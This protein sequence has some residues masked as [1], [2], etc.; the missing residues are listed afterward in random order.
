M[1]TCPNCNG[2]K[3]VPTHELPFSRPCPT[4]GG[5]G[6]ISEAALGIY[7]AMRPE[8]PIPEFRQVRIIVFKSEDGNEPWIPKRRSFLK[9]VAALPALAFLPNIP[10][11]AGLS[12]AALQRAANAARDALTSDSYLTFIHPSVWFDLR[13]L[14]ARELWRHEYRAWRRGEGD[15]HLFTLEDLIRHV[16]ERCENN[17]VLGMKKV[18]SETTEVRTYENFRFIVSPRLG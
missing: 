9:A 8:E 6:E 10:A 7:R 17:E 5:T 16:K 11:K 12:L 15:H 18:I 13:R 3:T 1:P 14:R 4:C 2:D